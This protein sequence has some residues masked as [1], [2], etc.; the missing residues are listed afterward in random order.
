MTKFFA[1]NLKFEDG[2]K[3]SIIDYTV[4]RNYEIQFQSYFSEFIYQPNTFF[5]IG[6]VSQISMKKNSIEFGSE[7]GSNYQ[8]SINTKYNQTQKGSFIGEFKTVLIN[9]NG[10]VNSAVGFEMMEG[11]KPGVNH[12]WSVGYQR[13]LSKNLQLSIQ[14]AGRKSEQLRIIHTGGMELRALF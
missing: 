3:L 4:N 14:Y 13:L 8:F 6:A 11:L 7:K 5:R 1:I 9:F 2:L 12:I 10:N